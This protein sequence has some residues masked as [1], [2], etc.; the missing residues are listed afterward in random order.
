LMLFKTLI[1]GWYNIIISGTVYNYAEV[2][3]CS[4]QK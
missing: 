2:M 4:S 3:Y 1:I